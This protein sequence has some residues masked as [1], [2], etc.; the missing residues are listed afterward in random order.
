MTNYDF[1]KKVSLAVFDGK[2]H[3]TDGLI[4]MRVP[5]WLRTVEDL[6]IEIDYINSLVSLNSTMYGR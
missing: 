6:K 1:T 2:L 3:I 4:T 5:S